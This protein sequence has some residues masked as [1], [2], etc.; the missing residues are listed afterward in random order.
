MYKNFMKDIKILVVEDSKVERN[1]LIDSLKTFCPTVLEASNGRIA[2]EVY[3]EN[4]DIDIILSDINMPEMSGVEFLKLIRKDDKTLPFLFL[5]AGTNLDEIL[6]VINLNI[7]SFLLKPI[8][9]EFLF[10][11]IN[12][13]CEKKFYEKEL[14]KKNDEVKNYYEAVDKV[15]LIYKMNENGDILYMN[16]LMHE[17]TKYSIQEIKKLNFDDIIHPNIPKKYINEVWQKLK[18]G[19]L[20]KGNT[21]FIDKDGETFYLK[22]TIFKIDSE[23]CEEY[24]TIAFLT[25]KENLEK[26]DFYKKVLTK[27]QESNKKEFELSKE[28]EYLKSELI[29][30]KNEYQKQLSVIDSLKKKNQQKES[31]ISHYEVVEN[32]LSEKYRKKLLQKKEELDSYIKKLSLEKSKNDRLEKENKNLIELSK[33]SK[34]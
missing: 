8:D 2:Y 19:E 25:T 3:L 33:K 21:K 32:D 13:L 23:D 26:R 20:W 28:N 12:S 11:K 14:K 9:K 31:Q 1:I 5:S 17:V 6:Q 7:T 29:S 10:E 18:N 24:I 4:K 30:Y 16:K 22:N 15:S 27:V 34:K